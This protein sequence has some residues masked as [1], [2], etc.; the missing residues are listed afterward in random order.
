MF[1]DKWPGKIGRLPL[2]ISHRSFCYKPENKWA[3]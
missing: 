1:D 3:E 2:E